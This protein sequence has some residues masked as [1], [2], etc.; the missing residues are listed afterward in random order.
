MPKVETL[1]LD[2]INKLLVEIKHGEPITI[3]IADFAVNIKTTLTEVEKKVFI[4]RV[5]DNSYTNGI[6]YSSIDN[7]TTFQATLAQI[8]TDLVI[9]TKED[10]PEIVDTDKLLSMLD[11]LK[12]VELAKANSPSFSALL[13]EL[14]MC[15]KEEID[16]KNQKLVAMY[17]ASS[18]SNDAIESV[19][20][21]ANG[22]LD[23]VNKL[24]DILDNF[25]DLIKD[26]KFLKVIPK[27]KLK[28]IFDGVQKIADSVVGSLKSND[29]ANSDNIIN[30]QNIKK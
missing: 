18:A 14:E 20:Y 25:K 2:K 27:D 4:K 10:N 15:I 8:L 23:A 7:R 19:S 11:G 12:L 13:N 30:I 3:P 21:L 28:I 9:P 16:F 1:I 24:C 22:A 6:E 5:V 17:A 29:N 26:G